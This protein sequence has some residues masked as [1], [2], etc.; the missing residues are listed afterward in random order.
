LSKI[1]EPGVRRRAEFFYLQ[2][3]G[4]QKLRQ[5]TRRD[6]WAES[7]PHGATKLLERRF[8]KCVVPNG[9]G[10]HR[11]RKSASLIGVEPIQR[12]VV[13]IPFSTSDEMSVLGLALFCLSGT[14]RGAGGS[15]KAGEPR[16]QGSALMG[17]TPQNEVV[18][19]LRIQ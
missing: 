8:E 10:P 7:R 18:L 16:L 5:E 14:E 11:V 6:L 17:S 12:V 1:T 13:R 15:I 19:E 2:L 3:D 9:Y 4:L